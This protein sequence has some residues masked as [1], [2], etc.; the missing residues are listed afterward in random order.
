MRLGVVG[1]AEPRAGAGGVEIAQRDRAQAGGAGKPAE[2]ALERRLGLAI[3]AH[4]RERLGL[5]QRRARRL[6]VDTGGRGEDEQAH[7][8]CEH[9]L[10]QMQA[11]DD[12]VAV[13]PVGLPH[14]LRH[15]DG[16]GHVDDRFDALLAQ[17]RRKA[18]AIS[19]VGDDEAGRRRDRCA[20]A[21]AEVVEDSDLVASVR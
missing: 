3:D 16:P 14:R 7:V 12:V 2:G 15:E 4:R 1:L 20:V 6:A 21:V 13:V 5:R 18:G 10:D 17:E 8:G 9:G 19:Q 11:I